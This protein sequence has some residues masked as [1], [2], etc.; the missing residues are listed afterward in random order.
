MNSLN[1]KDHNLKQFKYNLLTLSQNDSDLSFG[2]LK[3]RHNQSKV[4]S[5]FDYYANH[6]IP[7]TFD[8]YDNSGYSQDYSKPFSTE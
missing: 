7:K 4:P 2:Y 8:D 5:T 1:M 3:Q 6:Q